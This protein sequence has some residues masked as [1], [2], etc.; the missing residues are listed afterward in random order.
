MPKTCRESN[1]GASTKTKT[2][3][4]IYS[5]RITREITLKEAKD[6]KSTITIKD[7]IKRTALDY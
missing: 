2:I 7:K 3:G 6:P 4:K 5:P 1:V